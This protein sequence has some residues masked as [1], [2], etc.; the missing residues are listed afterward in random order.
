MRNVRVGDFVLTGVM[1]LNVNDL[2]GNYCWF[3]DTVFDLGSMEI[4]KATAHRIGHINH[5]L[6]YA[7]NPSSVTGQ[8]LPVMGDM[9]PGTEIMCLIAKS[10]PVI[11]FHVDASLDE[12]LSWMG[13]PS[14]LVEA[15]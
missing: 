12:V 9:P 5:C 1:Q 6:G 10:M 8:R 4:V 14:D 7:E 15:N 11:T 2:H 3:E 13:A